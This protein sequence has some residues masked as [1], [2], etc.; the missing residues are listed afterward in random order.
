MLFVCHSKILQRHCRQF[1]LGVKMAPRE[2]EKKLKK[3]LNE[4]EDVK[5]PKNYADQSA[6]VDIRKNF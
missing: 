6:E 4:A 5:N 1:L 3:L 2:T